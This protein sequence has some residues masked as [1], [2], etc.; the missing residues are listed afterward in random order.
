MNTLVSFFSSLRWQDAIDIVFNGYILFRLYVLFRGTNVFRVLV[1]IAFLWFFQRMAVSLGLIVT[2]WVMQGITAVAALIIIVVFR[3]EIRSVLQAKKLGAILWGIP[4]KGLNTPIEIVVDSVYEL[5]ERHEGALIVFPGKE[6]LTEAIHSGI[7]WNGLV[8]KEMILSIF[9]NDNPIHDGA[10]IIQGNYVKE[11]SAI[12]PLSHQKDLPS[13]Y[14]TRHR[15]AVGLAEVTDAMVIVV[16]EERGHVAVARDGNISVVGGKEKLEQILREHVGENPKERGYPKREKIELGVAALTSVILIAAV[17]FS[18]TRGMNT[19]I[20]LEIPIEYTNRDPATEILDTSVNS[21]LVHLSGS[22]ALI[23]SIR[24]DQVRV[25]ADLSR[26]VIGRNAFTISREDVTLTPGVILRKVEP[27]TVDVTLDK[28]VEKEVPIQ[29][30]WVGTLPQGLILIETRLEPSRVKLVG[31]S[32]VLEKI[33]T[34]YTEQVPLDAIEKTGSMTVR[35]ALD[36]GAL[37]VAAGSNGKVEV[38]YTI[39]KRIK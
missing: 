7:P 11:V 34:I 22:G 38:T 4:G 33:S 30:D 14:G 1:G 5:A 18:F 9:W 6:D 13:H 23:K 31:G 26:G 37:R 10:A 15:A 3:N 12:L 17:W 29:V 24:P 36:P 39:K 25:R 32:L 19:L 16:S 28:S 27:A 2:S 35:L 20:A 8:S 21:V